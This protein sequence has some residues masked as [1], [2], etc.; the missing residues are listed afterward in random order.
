M[1]YL[2]TNISVIQKEFLLPWWQKTTLTILRSTITTHLFSRN[3][4]AEIA[5][6]QDWKSQPSK[7]ESIKRK[8]GRIAQKSL[9]SDMGRRRGW[10]VGERWRYSNHNV[11]DAR[12]FADFTGSG[13]GFTQLPF[14]SRMGYKTARPY[15]LVSTEPAALLCQQEHS[16][17]LKT[18]RFLKVSIQIF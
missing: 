2:P 12:F 3:V 14:Q 5:N 8:P 4:R 6:S 7:S 1:I 18:S 16:H 15:V 9:T 13:N 10:S 11:W 17:Q